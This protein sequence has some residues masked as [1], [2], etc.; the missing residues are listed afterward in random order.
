MTEIPS[1]V[2]NFVTRSNIS[3]QTMLPVMTEGKGVVQIAFVFYGFTRKKEEVEKG[4]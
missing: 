1:G 2:E 3:Y 4:V